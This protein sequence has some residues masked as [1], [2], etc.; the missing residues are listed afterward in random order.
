M[1]INFYSHSFSRMSHAAGIA[2]LM[3]SA[4]L[5]TGCRLSTRSINPYSD[6]RLTVK[7]IHPQSSAIALQH[8][9]AVP[10]LPEEQIFWKVEAENTSD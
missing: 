1:K 2:F 8:R 3:L 9:S 4:A 5:F 10:V 7:I 6:A